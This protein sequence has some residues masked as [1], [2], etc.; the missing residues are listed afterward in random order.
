M[1]RNVSLL[2]YALLIALCCVACVNEKDLYEPSGGD[3]GETEELDL[4]FKFALRSDKQIHISVTRADGKAAEGIGVG[5]YLQQPY[6]EDGIISGK[7]LYMGYTDGNGQIDATISVPANSDKLYVASLTAGYP[8]VQ[9]MD[10]QP[11]MT[12]NLTAT[13]FQIKTATTRMVA[14]RSETGLDVPVDQKLS[15]LYELYSPYTDSE[16]G[17][18]GIPLLNASPLVTKEE[19]SAKFLNLMN[20]WYPEQKNVQDVDLKKSSDLVVTDELGAEVWAT[21]YIIL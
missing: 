1:K 9:E 5:V 18:D 8:G 15:N 2:K 10:V 3:P 12:C 21:R 11:S 16:I 19:L 6:E 17:K 20:S 7:P 13:A 14:T 4:S